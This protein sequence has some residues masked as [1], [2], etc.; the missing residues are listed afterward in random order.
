V[1]V[2]GKNIFVDGFAI[3]DITLS[4][5]RTLYNTYGDVFVYVC[6]C[7]VLYCLFGVVK[8]VTSP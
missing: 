6:I 2:N 7:L 1:Q 8:M 4:R 3:H 5:M